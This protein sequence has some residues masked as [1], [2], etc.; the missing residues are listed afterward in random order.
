MRS[1]AKQLALKQ[2]SGSFS[3]QVSFLAGLR[4]MLDD[5]TTGGVQLEILTRQRAI[6]AEGRLRSFGGR[7]HHQLYVADD[8]A[9]D[10]DTWDIGRFVAGAMHTAV[11][12]Y[13]TPELSWQLTV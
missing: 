9:S 13:A 3:G 1:R 12:A 4:R 5:C 11:P 10:E 8:V 6:D 7:D 2:K